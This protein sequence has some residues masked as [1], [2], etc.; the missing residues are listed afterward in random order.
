MFFKFHGSSLCVNRDFKIRWGHVVCKNKI[1]C[2]NVTLTRLTHPFHVL[3]IRVGPHS[4][5]SE[6]VWLASKAKPPRRL[7]RL[8]SEIVFKRSKIRQLRQKPL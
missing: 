3:S 4:G 8:E 5:R 1:A 6:R 7:H 2:G